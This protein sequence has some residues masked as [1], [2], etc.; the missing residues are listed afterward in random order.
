MEAGEHTCLATPFCLRK[1]RSSLAEALDCAWIGQGIRATLAELWIHKELVVQDLLSARV[2]G[3][4]HVFMMRM[5]SVQEMWAEGQQNGWQFES[6]FAQAHRLF[7]VMIST[8]EVLEDCFGYLSH[9]N[10]VDSRNPVGMSVE[11]VYFH[12]AVSPRWIDS[13]WPRIFLQ[14]GDLRSQEALRHARGKG[15]FLPSRHRNSRTYEEVKGVVDAGWVLSK[16]NPLSVN[17][18]RASFMCFLCPIGECMSH[19]PA[20]RKK[21]PSGQGLANA[22]QLGLRPAGHLSE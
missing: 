9:R 20:G 2:M 4:K 15:A 21:A 3:N 14:P 22:K 1:F 19:A 13:A 8:K 12:A 11:R 7:D 17:V 16:L 6:L 10:K 5:N 18:L